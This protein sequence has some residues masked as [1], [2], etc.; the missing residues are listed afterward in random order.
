MD[1]TIEARYRAIKA[2]IS[3][4][5]VE[6]QATLAL[7]LKSKHGIDANQVQVSRDLRKLG[8]GKK[9][10]ADRMV[11]ELPQFDQRREI[12]RLAIVDILH[13]ESMIVVKTVPGLAAFVGDHLD[14][15][16]DLELLG[17]LAGENIVFVT[18]ITTKEIKQTYKK[19]C[20]AL[21]YKK[22]PENV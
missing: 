16:E 18:P 15:E 1:S 20:G 3:E 19:V 9:K 2:I 11:Y 17:T 21:Y 13:N 10:V 7:L 14:Y 4:E 8:I 12:L 6:D 5:L 22:K